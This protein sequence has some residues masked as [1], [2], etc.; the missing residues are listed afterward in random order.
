MLLIRWIISALAVMAA[1]HIVPGITVHG[2]FSAFV[3]ALVFGLFNA[4]LRPV[5]I[6]LTLPI[7]ILTLGLF[8][9]VINALLFWFTSAIVKGFY[10]D[11]FGAAFFGALI[12]LLAGWVS[13]ILLMDARAHYYRRHY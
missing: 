12:M 9:L 6:F 11:G 7:T 1:A 10:V 2:L 8:T 3:V 5:L 4:V 13:N